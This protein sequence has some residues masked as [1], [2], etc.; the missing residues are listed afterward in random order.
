MSATKITDLVEQEAIDKIKELN[1][2][3][4]SLLDTY[5][6]TAK[7]LAKGLDVNIKVIGDIDRLEKLLSEKSKEAAETTG[8]LNAAIAEQGKVI[9]NTTNTISRQLMEQERVNKTQRQAYTEHERVKRLLDQYHDTYEGQIQSL[10]KINAELAKNKKG[11]AD[12]EKALASGRITMEQ[13]ATA[14]AS[15]VERQRALAQEKKSLTQLMAAEEKAAQ[16]Q[17]GSYVQLSQH[18]ELLKKAY[19]DLSAEGRESDFGKELEQSIQNLDAH[20]KDTA[21][22]MG[23]FQR[24]VG[25]YA[26]AG[27]NGV[28][29]TESLMAVLSQQAVTTKDLSD[30]S[31]ILMEARGMLDTTDAAYADTVAKINEKL[32]ENRKKLSD[33]SDT[34]NTQAKTVAEA[35]AQNKRLAEALKNVDQTSDGAGET[36]SALNAKIEEN[37]KVIEAGSGGKSSVKKDLKE[38]V[39]EIANLTIAYQN[40]SDEEKASAKG[41]EMAE[42]I[43]ELT[44]RAAELKDTIGDVNEAISNAASDTRGFDQVSEGIQLCI[45]GFGLA[46]GAAEML[47]ISQGDLVEIQTKLQAAI[48][49][50]NAMSK[51]QTAL[52]KQSALM[53][54]V[55]NLQTKAGAIAIKLKTAAE[56]KGVVTTKLLT[57]AQWLFNKACYANPIGIIVLAIMAFIA[58]AMALVKVFSLFSKD[59]E[60]RKEKYEEEAKALDDLK[61]SNEKAVEQAKARGASEW[62]AAEMSIEAKRSEMAQAEKAFKAAAAAYDED[63]DEY[64]EALEAKK[65]ATEDFLDIIEDSHNKIL[66]F[67]QKYADKE[68]EQAIGTAAFKKE[69][70]EKQ[71]REQYSISLNFYSEQ[72]AEVR[73]ILELNKVFLQTITDT[74]SALYQ[75]T[76]KTIEML[77]GRLDSLH[78]QLDGEITGLINAKNQIIAEAQ[79]EE[80]KK[81]ADAAKKAADARRKYQESVIKEIR[82]A[83]KMEIELIEEFGERKIALENFNYENE[84]SDLEKRLA[85]LGK[86]ETMMRQ[87]LQDQLR[88]LAFEHE[89]NLESLE[90]EAALTRLKVRKD[91][92]NSEL[93][94][95]KD[96]T[97]EHYSLRQQMLENELQLSV[98][99]VKKRVAACELTEEEGEELIRNLW[100]K[101]SRDMEA[102]AEDHASKLVEITQKNFADRQANEDAEV[103]RRLARLKSQYAAELAACKGGE[104]ERAAITARYEQ[105]AAEIQEDYAKEKHQA[106]IGYVKGLLETAGLSA[107]ERLKLE[108]QLAQAEIDLEN[109]IADASISAIT[110]VTEADT[111]AKEKRLENAQAWLQKTGEMLSAINDLVGAVYD[112]QTQRIEDEEE[113]NTEAGEREQERIARL[114]EQNVITQEDGEARKRAAEDLTAQKSAELEEKKAQIKHKQAVYDKALSV[115]N[116]GLNTAMAL[117]QLWVNPG[118]PAAIPMMAVVGALGALQLAT[119]LATPIPKYALGTDRHKGGP[120]IVGDGGR[121]EVVVYNDSA[122]L[123]PDT[124]TLVSLPA[125]ASVYPSVA[126]Y[127]ERVDGGLA[128]APS[129]VVNNDYKRLEEKMDKVIYLFL[130]LNRGKSDINAGNYLEILKISKGI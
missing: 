102:L 8:R 31:Q 77:Q 70:A 10:V 105:A 108:Q 103:G 129:V 71:F 2:E 58:A 17:E 36:I 88:F 64:K 99:G 75:T 13:Y 51:I 83:K 39:L 97:E 81:N 23:E 86:N 121:P 115:A 60:K 112:A 19:K 106:T 127:G 76:A 34:M 69:Q 55:A 21:A 45:D 49:A 1:V 5:T 84:K 56:G 9:A 130:G 122:W 42:H 80:D 101:H 125:G 53:Q 94:L 63:K 35:E 12:N 96:G 25:N 24:N 18:L 119:A 104:A 90:A 29:A 116:I 28:V 126:D 111:K 20:L 85:E 78:Q 117:M 41:Q 3:I 16:A 61:K 30:Q 65:K 120:A 74:E 40:L 72:M 91:F 26:I 118:W 50:S 67:I 110:R 98:E 109:A 38:L 100:L 52:Q 4:K 95:V 62:A 82:R 46:T 43:R 47:G 44:E 37:N 48:A 14:Q 11:Q 114:V 73:K 57:A 89:R 93:A 15:L 68:R 107:E 79:A 87:A 6:A 27:Q 113:A 33:V 123:T 59:S 124:P 66:A 54:G 7:E 92:I 32:A 128:A 22:D